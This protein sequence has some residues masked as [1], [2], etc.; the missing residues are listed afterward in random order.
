[1]VTF[2]I[3][4]IEGD[5][6]V[7]KVSLF[8]PWKGGGIL[9]PVELNLSVNELLSLRNEID[10]ATGKAG[11]LF[12]D[13]VEFVRSIAHSEYYINYVE[14]PSGSSDR[15]Q[16]LHGLRFDS[17]INR[18]I[19]VRARELYAQSQVQATGG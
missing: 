2:Q 19:E 15:D 1:M 14:L 13:L 3:R 4:E 7:R 10:Q 11:P 8:V 16:E 18:E 12:D 5:S 6:Q 17:E 9:C